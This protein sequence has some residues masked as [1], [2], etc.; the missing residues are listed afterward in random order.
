MTGHY[1][2]Q[3]LQIS[4]S[5]SGKWIHKDE[6]GWIPCDARG[7]VSKDLSSLTG[8]AMCDNDGLKMACPYAGGGEFILSH[9]R[10][11]FAVTGAGDPTVNGMYR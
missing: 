6:A 1:N 11:K 10:T 2:S 4:L 5:F 7:I 3:T 8:D 9:D